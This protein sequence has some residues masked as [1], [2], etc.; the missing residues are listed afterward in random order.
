MFKS[1]CLKVYKGFDL[2]IQ[3]EQLQSFY[4]MCVVVTVVENINYCPDH[5]NSLIV[6]N[7]LRY[8][9][10]YCATVLP[11]RI[12]STLSL[13]TSTQLN[14]CSCLRA[15]RSQVKLFQ[16]IYNGISEISSFSLGSEK[17][18]SQNYF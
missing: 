15:N 18:T 4:I 9:E 12:V 7:V 3:H 14:K 2:S 11:H 6:L 16:R 8:H 1:N 5:I 10:L 17:N 13:F